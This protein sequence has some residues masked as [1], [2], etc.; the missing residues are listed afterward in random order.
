VKLPLMCLK[1]L[2]YV[3]SMMTTYGTLLTEGTVDQTWTYTENGNKWQKIF[4]IW[5]VLLTISNTVI[6]LMQITG[7][8]CILLHLK[9]LGKTTR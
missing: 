8:K 9:K 4:A 7:T 1:E 2:D 3:T 6:L 5:N